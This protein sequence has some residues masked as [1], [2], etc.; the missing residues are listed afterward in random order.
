L[1]ESFA[2]LRLEGLPHRLVV[3]G[4]KVWKSEG[5][6]QRV[7]DLGLGD[8]VVLT[9]YVDDAD[10]PALYAGAACFVFPS[11][12]EGFGLPPLEAMACGVP[13]VTSNASSLPEVVGDAAIMVDPHDVAGFVAAIRQIVDQP[14]LADHLRARGLERAQGFSWERAAAA[15]ASLYYDVFKQKRRNLGSGNTDQS[16]DENNRL[17]G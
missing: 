1:F 16:V 7:D 10:L 12:Y 17:R 13:V 9:G 5:I 14:A 2:R 6:F 15:H 8:A 11:I 4:R 3:V